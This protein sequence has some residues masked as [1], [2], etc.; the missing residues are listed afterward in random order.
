MKNADSLLFVRSLD[1]ERDMVGRSVDIVR[2][3]AH[4]VEI[5]QSVE[6]P[7]REMRNV[8]DS[9]ADNHHQRHLA[10]RAWMNV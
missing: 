10:M 5:L 6:N 1:H 7:I 2:N 3:R 8:R 9:D 4:N